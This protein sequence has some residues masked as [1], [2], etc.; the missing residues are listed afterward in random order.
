MRL[1]T[2]V[3]VLTCMYIACLGLFGV[4][5]YF[6]IRQVIDVGLK[7]IVWNVWCGSLGC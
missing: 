6:L 3:W 5:V 7:E 2:L 1:P 4:A